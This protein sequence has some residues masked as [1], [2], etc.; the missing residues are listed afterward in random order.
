M[1]RE[2]GSQSPWDRFDKAN[3]VFEMRQHMK[4][5]MPALLLGLMPLSG[6][7]FQ[8]EV[9]SGVSKSE[10]R[11]LDDFQSVS[12][13]GSG[14]FE[15]V[16]DND[17]AVDLT[18][19][20]N[21]LP[22]VSCEV[23]GGQLTLK[24]DVGFNSSMG[25]SGTIHAKSVNKIKV[26]GSGELKLNGFD[27]EDLSISVTGSGDCKISGQVG[28]LTATVTGSGHIDTS[29]LASQ[30]VTVRIVGSGDV[31]VHA[32]DSLKASITGSGKIHYSGEAKVDKS[33][34]GSGDVEKVA[35]KKKPS[36]PDTSQ[37]DGESQTETQE[38]GDDQ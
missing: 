21:L 9:G 33:V 15:I 34:T 8:M 25:L 11:K 7:D 12:L 5:L 35:S 20:D 29:E 30:Q 31:N 28:T 14:E 32:D 19:D 17:H 3:N 24:P 2:V 6:C 26:T 37:T 13:L 23:S 36:V 10:T 22:F 4:W 16:L 27:G 18:F 38:T 1:D